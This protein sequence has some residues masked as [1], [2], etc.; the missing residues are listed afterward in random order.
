[1]I[2]EEADDEVE[3][4][5]GLEIVSQSYTPPAVEYW[6]VP[7]RKQRKK[8]A[9][10]LRVARHRRRR[11]V[12]DSIKNEVVCEVDLMEA[13]DRRSKNGAGS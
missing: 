2:E 13:D 11:I 1:M 7:A 9:T 12:R 6:E 5:D 4:Q 10:A 3:M 8:S